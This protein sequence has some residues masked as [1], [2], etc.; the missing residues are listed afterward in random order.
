MGSKLHLFVIA[1]NLLFTAVI[2]MALVSIAI[3]LRKG[4]NK[5]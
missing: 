2:A 3:S 4:S 1:L 5:R